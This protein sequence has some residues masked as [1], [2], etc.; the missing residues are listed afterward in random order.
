VR[1]PTAKRYLVLGLILLLMT[2]SLGISAAPQGF[3]PEMRSECGDD[4]CDEGE[5][6]E[7]CPQ[8]CGLFILGYCGDGICD[9]GEESTCTEDCGIYCVEAIC[10]EGEYFDW[11]L[12]SCLPTGDTCL[13]Q[14]CAPGETFD[15]DLCQC[16]GSTYCG[17]GNCDDNE[18]SDNCSQ[19]CGPQTPLTYC[20]D[21]T[22]DE[23]ENYN[24]C[25][26]DCPP[27]APAQVCGDGSCDASSEDYK[28]CPSDCPAP[29]SYCGDGFCDLA[30]EN[31]TDCPQ[32]CSTITCG[33]STCDTQSGE[34]SLTCP[35]DCTE[36]AA[37]VCGDG[38]CETNLLESH[39]NCPGDCLATCGN[40]SCEYTESDIFNSGLSPVQESRKTCPSDCIPNCG[41]KKCEAAIGE[42][43]SNCPSDCGEESSIKS[44]DVQ[45]DRCREYYGP[46]DQFGYKPLDCPADCGNGICETLYGETPS[47]CQLDCQT[48]CGDFRC[49]LD[50]GE[51]YPNCPKDCAPT[52]GDGVCDH[53]KETVI[54]CPAD[55]PLTALNCDDNQCAPGEA[56][57]CPECWD[58]RRCDFGEG[59]YF[60]TADC[61]I[62]YPGCSCYEWTARHAVSPGIYEGL[63]TVYNKT[64]YSIPISPLL[65]V[66]TVVFRRRRCKNL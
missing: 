55:C 66:G 40:N 41:N 22:C 9:V 3:G 33:N 5:D 1:H 53:S 12:C 20:G 7:N 56:V 52:C 49:D 57:A 46:G 43:Y 61:G 19:D 64:F 13:P 4:S 29:T 59:S 8:D 14:S 65:L 18:N 15:T 27:P 11:E 38:V 28:S 2:A 48:V 21:G 36:L 47:N 39:N 10:A 26:Q 31:P 44:E 54:T 34:D 45:S 51:T 35:Q 23:D 16:V 42:V 6:T 60:S 30:S 37:Y 17:D 24:T 63:T 58:D 50:A 32:D 25:A 62:V